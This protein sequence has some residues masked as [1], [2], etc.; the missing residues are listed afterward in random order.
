M[1][2]KTSSNVKKVHKEKVTIADDIKMKFINCKEVY[3]STK[4]TFVYLI[5]HT[6]LTKEHTINSR[7]FLVIFSVIPII[8]QFLITGVR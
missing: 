5:V 2:F 1:K 7:W 3:S 4:F 8:L 6:R